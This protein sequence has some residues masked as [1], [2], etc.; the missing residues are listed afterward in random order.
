MK[1]KGFRLMEIG[2]YFIAH[3][4]LIRVGFFVMIF[5]AVTILET[6][7][8]RRKLLTSKLKRWVSNFLL[9]LIDV[10]ILRFLLPVF[11]VGIALMCAARGWGLLNNVALLPLSAFI[12]GVVALDLA[13]YL[14]HMMFHLT[15]LF[16]R[17]H[18]VHHTDRDIDVSTGLRFHPL[19]IIISLAIKLAVVAA[20]GAPPLAVLVFEI[21]LNGTTMFNH[22]NLRLPLGADR[23]IR[24]IVV[25]PDMH[26]VHHSNLR[27]E[28]NSNYGF[29][30]SFWDRLFGTY[31]AQPTAGH[32]EMTIGLNGYRDERRLKILP[33]LLLP[34]TYGK[35]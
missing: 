19:E 14:Q 34:F 13:I 4:A 25:T 22:G 21:L 33:L 23:I 24:M 6:L 20:L 17:V 15:P 29:N 12:I 8:P 10:T 26:R 9:Q 16:W 1:V 28:T 30:F 31:R 32:E 18:M 11:P 7:T 27:Q 3:E 2:G 5:S 35:E